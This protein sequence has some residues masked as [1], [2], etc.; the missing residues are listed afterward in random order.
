MRQV[1]GILKSLWEIL[2]QN[3]EHLNT[4]IRLRKIGG[5]QH[6]HTLHHKFNMKQASLLAKPKF[7]VLLLPLTCHGISI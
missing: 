1:S 5:N 6:H 2:H 3:A 7:T 4:E